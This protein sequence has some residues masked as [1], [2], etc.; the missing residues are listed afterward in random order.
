MIIPLRSEQCKFF[1]IEAINGDHRRVEGTRHDGLSIDVDADQWFLTRF[2]ESWGDPDHFDT[3]VEFDSAVVDAF[4]TSVIAMPI[5]FLRDQQTSVKNHCETAVC[6]LLY[7]QPGLEQGSYRRVGIATM[8]IRSTKVA[9][10]D[11]LEAALREYQEPLQSPWYH[12]INGDGEYVI[13]V[14]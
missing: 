8:R 11:A 13:S 12:E 2:E 4:R 6:L 5:I 9:S 14:V 1:N 10:V 7:S 3:E